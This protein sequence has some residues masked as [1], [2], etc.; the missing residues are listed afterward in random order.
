[1]LN[2]FL[3]Q[4]QQISIQKT[5]QFIS[6]INGVSQ[7]YKK[8]NIFFLF[9]PVSQHN[10]Q[11]YKKANI[12]FS[13]DPVSQHIGWNKRRP[14]RRHYKAIYFVGKVNETNLVWHV[15]RVM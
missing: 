1:L 5:F 2:T 8:A 12:F 13:F 6:S 11:T 9:D 7:T 4:K 15:I 3:L 10:S 14:T